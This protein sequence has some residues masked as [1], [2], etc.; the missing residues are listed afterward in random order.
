[1]TG[2]GSYANCTTCTLT[3]VPAAGYSFS[4]WTNYVSHD[5][6]S[7]VH[8]FVVW[9]DQNLTANFVSDSLLFR[10]NFDTPY[11]SAGWVLVNGTETN[12]W[13]IGP[14]T[15]T[16]EPN[17]IYISNTEGESNNYDNHNSSIVW[18]YRPL[19]LSNG[20][21]HYS[22]SWK[23]DGENNN[24][25][26][27]LFLV[28]DTTT[29]VAGRSPDG[30]R[31]ISHYDETWIPQDWIR[32][33]DRRLNLHS[34]WQMVDG[35]V[36][37]TSG[38]YKLVLLW[39][40]DAS[41]GNNPPAAVDDIFFGIVHCQGI[42]SIVADNITSNSLDLSWNANGSVSPWVVKVSSE[43]VTYTDITFTPT[44][45]VEWLSPNTEYTVT[46]S[47]DCGDGSPS[48]PGH[49]TFY[50]ACSTLNQLPYTMNFEASEDDGYRFDIPDCWYRTDTNDRYP[51]LRSFSEYNH[52]PNGSRGLSWTGSNW[53]CRA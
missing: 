8:Q 48:I 21:Y 6:F 50:T 7:P 47:S 10:C 31:W 11:D 37:V 35:N 18:A 36:Y 22:Y 20:T 49:T 23:A 52:T 44:L 38:N 51:Y 53:F 3:A 29:L 25:W 13:C 26:L 4:H 41:S 32:L 42:D 15:S 43:D 45:H 2:T 19:T 24:D 39:V 17:S 34:T 5:H 27:Y 9:D 1:M 16:S 33:C 30:L 12:R 14:A 40:N 46:I 28:P